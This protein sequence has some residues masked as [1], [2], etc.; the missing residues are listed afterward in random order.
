MLNL[1][2]K[3]EIIKDSSPEEIV[4]FFSQTLNL[5]QE[6]LLSLIKENIS[7]EILPLLNNQDFKELGI[8][9]G[10]QK[11]IQKYIEDN[12]SKL[13]KNQTEPEINVDSEQKDVKLFFENCLD[14]EENVENIDGKILFS[15]AEQDLK[16]LG[17]NIGQR[18][19]LKSVIE[20]VKKITKKTKI[21]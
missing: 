2:N 20:F 18:K 19:K 17:L 15:M 21:K 16:K 5:K 7:G 10:H 11:R 1:N 6:N 8:K 13:I 14:F 12:L 9:L 3:Q 4:K